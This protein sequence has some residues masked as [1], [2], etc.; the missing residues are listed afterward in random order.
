MS[1]IDENEPVVIDLR[2]LKAAVEATGEAILITSAELD[3]PGPRIEY[4]NAAFVRLTGYALDEV[5]GRSPRLLQ[6]PRTERAELDRA[7]SLLEAGGSLPRRDA[8]LPQGRLDLHGRV[9]DHAG[10]GSRR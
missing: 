3:E 6:G 7:R 4:A 5:I 10:Q 2:L 1:R 9:V 8:E